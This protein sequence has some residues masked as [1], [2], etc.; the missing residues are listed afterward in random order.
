MRV[1]AFLVV[2]RL[3]R[4]NNV[5]GARSIAAKV[6]PTMVEVNPTTVEVESTT[7]DVKLT[8]VE[9]D[10]V[11]EEFDSVSKE[12]D[13]VLVHLNFMTTELVSAD[14]V[15]IRRLVHTSYNLKY[16]W[17]GLR[18]VSRD[19]QTDS[20]CV[21]YLD[22]CTPNLLSSRAHLPG[23]AGP[24]SRLNFNHLNKIPPSSYP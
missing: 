23:W 4:S 11:T 12:L 7:L 24:P 2:V 10:S 22:F 18:T 21:W 1:L 20:R 8:V 9:D 16:I 14:A 13:L 3:V 6:H 19:T 5:I 17:I 15:L